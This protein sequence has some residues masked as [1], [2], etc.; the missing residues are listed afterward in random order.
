MSSLTL[1]QRHESWVERLDRFAADT[2][3]VAEFCRRE[4]VSVS[5][6]YVWKKRLALT[7]APKSR[8]TK[9]ETSSPKFVPLVV[10]A[11]AVQPMLKLPGGATIELPSQLGG[12][13]LVDLIGAVVEATDSARRSSEEA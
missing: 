10:T 6:F 11:T 12:Q 4:A 5:N 8:S 9:S 1:Q 2:S 7:S 13:Q 3:T